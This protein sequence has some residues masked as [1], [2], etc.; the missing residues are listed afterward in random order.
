MS[1]GTILQVANHIKFKNWISIVFEFIPQILFFWLIFGYLGFMIVFKWATDWYSEGLPPPNLLNTLIYMFLS[2]GRVDEPLFGQGTN[3]QGTLQIAFLI[4]AI[5]AIPWMLLPKPFILKAQHNAKVKKAKAAAAAVS[6]EDGNGAD[7][8]G[9][10]E[11]NI[12]AQI[13]R[14]TE[15]AI[16]GAAPLNEVVSKHEP[17]HV[18]EKVV[19]GEEGEEVAAVA[20]HEEHHSDGFEFGEIMIYQ[21][22]HTIEYCLGCVSNTASYLRLWALSLA[23]ARGLGGKRRAMRVCCER[24]L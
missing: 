7:E 9:H 21:I 10:V 24:L 1:F 23:H 15:A 11:E 14:E 3:L 6:I 19:E 5:V 18:A 2:P 17:P 8:H 12:T 4:I 13:E 22:I 20:H 16:A